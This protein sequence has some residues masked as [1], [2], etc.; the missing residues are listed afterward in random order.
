MLQLV[1]ARSWGIDLG[2]SVLAD[3]AR[4]VEVLVAMVLGAALFVFQTK[5]LRGEP[6]WIGWI[7]DV[8]WLALL[9]AFFVWAPRL[10]LHHRVTTRDLF[11]G[12]VFTVLGLVILRL[13]SVLLLHPLAELVLDHLRRVRD[14]HRHLLLDHPDGTVLVLA[15]ALS[16]ALAERRDLLAGR[17]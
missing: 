9:L 4:Y 11:P 3:Q 14:H 7:L 1:H 15:A 5:A 6:S 2:K 13:I 10:S 8:G 17:A 12:A 16:P